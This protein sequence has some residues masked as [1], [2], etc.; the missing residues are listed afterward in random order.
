MLNFQMKLKWH[1]KSRIIQ[2]TS[3][4]RLATFNQVICEKTIEIWKST[5]SENTVEHIKSDDNIW[6]DMEIHKF[7][8]FPN[9]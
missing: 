5:Y 9:I 1:L 8:I 3:L 7:N 2:A 4:Q 6:H